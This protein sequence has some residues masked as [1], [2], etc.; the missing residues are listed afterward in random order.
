MRLLNRCD[1]IRSRGGR[2]REAGALRLRWTRS[3]CMPLDGRGSSRA[4]GLTT[5][6]EEAA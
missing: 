4:L 5:N 1:A 3:E 6:G 2:Q